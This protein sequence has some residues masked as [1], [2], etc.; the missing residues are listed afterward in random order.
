MANLSNAG[1]FVL[2]AGVFGIGLL[3]VSEQMEQVNVESGDT[4]AYDAVETLL[5]LQFEISAPL[6]FL[7]AV[8]FMLAVF[9]GRL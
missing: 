4:E 8:G 3:A 2:V 9:S 1:A 6:I 7:L 5:S